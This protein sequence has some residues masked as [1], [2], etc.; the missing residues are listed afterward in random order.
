MPETVTL[1]QMLE[2]RERRASRQR[3]LLAPY[4]LPLVS[5]AGASG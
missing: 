1:E 5:S 2:A 3:A 4:A